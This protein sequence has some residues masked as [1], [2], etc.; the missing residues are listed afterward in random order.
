MNREDLTSERA[1]D[2]ALNP[3][4]ELIRT[5]EGSADHHRGGKGT[6]T[7]TCR[8]NDKCAQERRAEKI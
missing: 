5:S 2:R 3:Q 8:E 4:K 7:E 6:K 1:K